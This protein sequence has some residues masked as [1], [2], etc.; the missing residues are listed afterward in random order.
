MLT[1]SKIDVCVCYCR[2]R[3]YQT[4]RSVSALLDPL[5]GNRPMAG[6]FL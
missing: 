3:T 4:R 2:S 5:C 6:G 1:L